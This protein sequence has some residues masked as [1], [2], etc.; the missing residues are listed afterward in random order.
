M[1][2]PDICGNT[3]KVHVIFGKDGKNHLTKKEIDAPKDEFTHLYTLRVNT[4]NTYVVSVDNAKVHEGSLEDDFDMVLPK[5][6]KDPNAKKPAG[7]LFDL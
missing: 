6:I 4:D 5:K 2:G 1:F 3:H 7:V